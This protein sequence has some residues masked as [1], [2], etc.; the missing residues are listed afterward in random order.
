MCDIVTK[1]TVM[2]NRSLKQKSGRS[3]YDSDL[4]MAEISMNCGGGYMPSYSSF[5]NQPQDILYI[6]MAWFGV[7]FLLITYIL[8]S[9][10]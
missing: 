6:P 10:N 1:P 9:L 7:G 5:V 3:D 2:S 4:I 8:I